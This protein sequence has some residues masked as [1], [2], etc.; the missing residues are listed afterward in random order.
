MHM[1]EVVCGCTRRRR[2]P[3]SLGRSRGPARG[4]VLRR[5]NASTVSAAHAPP[6]RPA[7]EQQGGQ[8]A[9]RAGPR[10]RVEE[11]SEPRRGAAGALLQRGLHAHQ[12]AAI[13][14]DDALL[15]RASGCPWGP[16]AEGG[17]RPRQPARERSGSRPRWAPREVELV[18]GGDVE[19]RQLLL[20]EKPRT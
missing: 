15:S 6:A 19:R 10:S 8:N 5:R 13:Y 3:A 1:S 17:T 2:A 9:P 11:V 20:T 16:E 14:G 7:R 18:D 4:A 12:R